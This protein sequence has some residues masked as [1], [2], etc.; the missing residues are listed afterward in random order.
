[1]YSIWCVCVEGSSLVSAVYSGLSSGV[2]FTTLIVSFFFFLKVKA[3]ETTLESPWNQ[4]SFY[5]R[6]KLSYV[7]IQQPDDIPLQYSMIAKCL[8][9]AFMSK[10]PNNSVLY[11]KQDDFKTL[12]MSHN[13]SKQILFIPSLSQLAVMFDVVGNTGKAFMLTV[14]HFFYVAIDQVW[15][16]LCLK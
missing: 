1:M 3:A 6:S 2:K 15:F 13:Q 10:L 9:L 5:I 8:D 7:A 11:L 12:K 16:L 14:W 4:N